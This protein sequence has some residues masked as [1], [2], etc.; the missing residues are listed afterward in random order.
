MNVGEIVDA[1][2]L[3]ERFKVMPAT[4]HAWQ[5]R[6]WIPCLKAGRRP[7]LFDLGA[8]E[9]AL[10]QRGELKGEDHAP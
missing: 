10:R 2:Q 1:K 5:R 9:Q 7:V 3:A 6:G 4:I 8:V